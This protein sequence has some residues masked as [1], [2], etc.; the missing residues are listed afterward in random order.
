MESQSPHAKYAVLR[1]RGSSWQVDH[2]LVPY[3]WTAA[4]ATAKQN[5]RP[6]WAEW[7]TRGRV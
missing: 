2:L 5:G 6:D 1:P 3:D 4:A 7:L